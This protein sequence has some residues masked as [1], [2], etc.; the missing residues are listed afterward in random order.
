MISDHHRT[1]QYKDHEH[2]LWL[3]EESSGWA[4]VGAVSGWAGREQRLAEERREES[5]GWLWL[6]R[7]ERRAER[8]PAQKRRAA[9]GC[10]RGEESRAGR[11]SSERVKA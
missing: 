6:R 9:A 3:V 8:Q 2:P 10:G 11:T 4:A 7:G 1:H 5:G